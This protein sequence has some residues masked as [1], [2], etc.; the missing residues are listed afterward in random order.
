MRISCVF[1]A[2]GLAF[3]ALDV[4]AP[5]PAFASSGSGIDP[6]TGHI[7]MTLV[8][9]YVIPRGRKDVICQKVWPGNDRRQKV[10]L[11]CYSKSGGRWVEN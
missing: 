2:A 4:P 8:C 11:K 1:A 7:C 5:A 3:A 6:D 10:Q 9:D